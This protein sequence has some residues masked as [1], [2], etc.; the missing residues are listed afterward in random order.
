MAKFKSNLVVVLDGGMAN[1]KQVTKNKTYTR[2]KP[3]ATDEN[4]KAVGVALM[5]LSKD[6][7]IEY[8]R[9]DTSKL[10]A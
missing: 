3:T 6:T 4:A 9:V 5:A 1:G 8:N 2:L 7:V 10:D